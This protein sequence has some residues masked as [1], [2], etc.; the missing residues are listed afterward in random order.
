MS[1]LFSS[2]RRDIRRAPQRNCAE[3]TLNYDSEV[4]RLRAFRR[5][6]AIKFAALRDEFKRVQN[7]LARAEMENIKLREEIALANAKALEAVVNLGKAGALE[8]AEGKINSLESELSNGKRRI[9]VL[10]RFEMKAAVY[11][12]ALG[13]TKKEKHELE[14]ALEQ[15]REKIKKLE[16]ELTAAVNRSS[17]EFRKVGLHEDCPDFVLKAVRQIY[18]KELHPDPKPIHLKSEAEK[19]FK[20]AEAVFDRLYALRRL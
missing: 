1:K 11:E 13:S 4:I 15:A 3:E 8:D 16:N 5:E 7:R 20:D 10:E 14:N 18:R 6:A 9:R 2:R 12:K 19:R 17:R